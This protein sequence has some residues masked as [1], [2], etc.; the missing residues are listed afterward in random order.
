M[1]NSMLRNQILALNALLLVLF[2]APTAFAQSGVA[3]SATRLNNSQP[4]IDQD[5]FADLGVEDEGENINGP[6]LI[7]IPDWI[8]PAE[9]ADPS[10]VYYLY[11]AH[12]IGDYIR[13]AWATDVEG[14]WTL[15][16]TGA[17]VPIGQR[18]VLDNGDADLDLGLGVVIE[19]NH[20]ASPD[21][22]IDNENQQIIMYFHSGSSTFFNGNEINSQN[23]WVSTSDFGLEFLPNIRPVRLGGSYFRV[24]SQGG[25]LYSLDNTGFPRRALDPDNPWQ[26]TADYYSGTT[27]P[28]LWERHPDQVLQDPIEDLGIPRSVLRV[29]HTATRIVG[30]Q[31]QV[32][33]TQRGDSPE[34]V[35]FSTIDLNVPD[36]EDWRLTYPGQ[37][38]IQ[39][40]PGWE[41][42]QFTARP[43]EAGA[44]DEDVNEL[45]DPDVFED[46]DGSLYLIY[47]G[48]GE[49]ALGIAKLTSTAGVY[50]NSTQFAAD[51]RDEVD[52][53]TDNDPTFGYQLNS[54]N[55]D[56]IVPYVNLNQIVVDFNQ[57]VDVNSLDISDFVLTADPGFTVLP[58][59]TPVINGVSVDA[60][61][62]TAVRVSL[63]SSLDAANYELEVNASGITFGGV[64]GSD[65]SQQFTVLPGDINDDAQVLIF[66][67]LPSITLIGS[68]IGDGNYS[69]RS[70]LN[71]DGQIL[72][73]DLL[74]SLGRIG[75]FIAPTPSPGQSGGGVF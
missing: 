12:H 54:D 63:S 23:T 74:Q 67:I 55:Q 28:S 39:A 46:I 41:G 66:D 35:Q 11:F 2:L 47:A 43:S 34:R 61:D 24:F 36:W 50:L 69:L 27:I 7:R 9:R 15:Y 40:I 25:E 57:A 51:F 48:R 33:Y 21:V 17:N 10:A 65:F 52:G 59:I 72:I 20:L 14:P 53:S 6:S 22:L 38:I 58:G 13:L 18:G 29:R 3:F 30:D 16:Q 49:D 64:A 8:P 31:L 68:L 60:S 44:A 56:A 73:F 42:G 26:P 32:F 45:R 75:N 37:E 70:D 62:P 5:M 71:G 19:E 4:I 1:K